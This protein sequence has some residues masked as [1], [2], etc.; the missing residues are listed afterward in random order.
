MMVLAA[1]DQVPRDES[2]D[3]RRDRVVPSAKKY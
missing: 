1:A 3:G 2:E